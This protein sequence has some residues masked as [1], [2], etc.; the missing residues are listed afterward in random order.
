MR[1]YNAAMAKRFQFSMRRLFIGTTLFGVGAALVH[2]VTLQ[3]LVHS[4][5]ELCFVYGAFFGAPTAFVAG[6]GAIIET[7][8]RKLIRPIAILLLFGF[9]F[10]TLATIAYFTSP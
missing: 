7:D 1:C 6:C 2:A 3:T 5:G 10:F 8:P 9:A 4:F